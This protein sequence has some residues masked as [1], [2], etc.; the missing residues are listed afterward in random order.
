MVSPLWHSTTWLSWCIWKIT[1]T[2]SSTQFIYLWYLP[3]IGRSIGNSQ[4]TTSNNPSLSLN[5]YLSFVRDRDGGLLWR[6]LLYIPIH[7]WSTTE[8]K[9]NSRVSTLS[10]N[11][12]ARQHTMTINANVLD[13][14]QS[15]NWFLC[16]F[17]TWAVSASIDSILQGSVKD[18]ESLAQALMSCR[19]I[20]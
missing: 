1:T 5:H 16:L 20:W 7:A 9:K 12:L 8:E 13:V 18:V 11:T 15:S 4:I 2:K 6:L 10:T 3:A 14:M 19:I 17:N